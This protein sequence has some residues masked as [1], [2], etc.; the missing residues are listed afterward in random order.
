MKFFRQIVKITALDSP[1]VKLA[2]AQIAAG[3]SPNGKM[4]IQG[5]LSWE[6]YCHRKATWLPDRQCRGL[7]AEFYEGPSTLL[8]PEEW[9]KLSN[10]LWR[11]LQ[12]I[13]GLK[14]KPSSMG[15]DPGEG[16][17]NTCWAI[18]DEYGLIELISYPT[19]DTAKIIQATI[20]YGQK[21]GIP[22]IQWIFD[23]GSGKQHADRLRELGYGVRTVGFGQAPQ[24]D[25]KRG[26]TR[27]EE[28]ID[29][30]EEG[31]RFLNRRAQ[32]Y[33]ELSEL[34]D[35]SLERVLSNGSKVT[36][37]A[38]PPDDLGPQY[39]ELLLEMEPIPKWT[40]GEG[41][42]YLP[43]KDRASDAKD[44]ERGVTLKDLIGHSPDE[45]D[46]V[47]LMVH[48]ILHKRSPR[49]AGAVV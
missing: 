11:Y 34:M 7:D 20:G 23:R 38:L 36:G 32:M 15:I 4:V 37:Y 49:I 24:I 8:Y 6:A 42:L 22:A 19:P 25:P 5:V 16:V 12:L 48:G 10:D 39:K 18:G 1:N 43:P 13:P 14:R 31:Y 17:A 21:H 41:R 46:A 40:D 9:R 45:L 27:V 30:R 44:V 33:G 35:P 29:V 26:M 47:V 3:K 28:K 2:L